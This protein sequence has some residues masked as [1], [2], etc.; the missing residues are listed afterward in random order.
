M[1]LIDQSESYDLPFS[2]P[3]SLPPSDQNT[4]SPLISPLPPSPF[5]SI[6]D[7]YHIRPYGSILPRENKGIAF[8]NTFQDR[9]SP[10]AEVVF[11][12]IEAE[13]FISISRTFSQE[14]VVKVLNTFQIYVHDYQ[15][16]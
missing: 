8:S 16:Y 12:I 6:A 15:T 10:V 11:Q 9:T 1:S 7:H 4:T 2:F 13:P 5:N 3:F 14:I